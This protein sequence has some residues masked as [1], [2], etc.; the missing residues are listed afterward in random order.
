MIL[1][2]SNS[3]MLP[4]NISQ[5]TK[6]IIIG[7]EKNLNVKVLMKRINPQIIFTVLSVHIAI[8]FLIWGGLSTLGAGVVLLLPLI[9]GTSYVSFQKGKQYRTNTRKIVSGEL[10]YNQFLPFRG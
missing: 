8:L 10:N 1:K 7:L 6:K 2:S 9:G 3:N 5:L 4:T